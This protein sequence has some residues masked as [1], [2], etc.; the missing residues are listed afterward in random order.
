MS[1]VLSHGRFDESEF[2]DAVAAARERI[3]GA[4]DELGSK[5]KLLADLD[6]WIQCDFGRWMLLNGG[7]NGYWTR[8]A[9]LYPRSLAAGEPGTTNEVEHFFLTQLPSVV[10][11]Q[12]RYQIFQATFSRLIAP[13]AVVLSI[14]CGAMD[15]LLT[16]PDLP[17]DVQ[18]IGA[19]VDEASLELAR[20]TA[21]DL[22]R[23]GQLELVQADAWELSATI[24]QL[25][26]LVTS[27]GL[28]IYE[29]DDDRVVE[30][31][32]S[33][34]S[35]LKQGGR[36]VTSALT[37]RDGWNAAD[38][39]ASTLRRA[40]G[41]L[42]INGVG[43]SNLRTVEQTVAQLRTAGLRIEEVLPDPHGIFPTFVA[44]KD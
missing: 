4:P 3:A 13:G 34:A 9:V 31:Y 12:D 11:T 32:R 24:S 2:D 42:L 29:P 10:A 27:N 39:P 38:I 35:V 25:C 30:L 41:M 14:P 28:N 36:V 15:D 33:F 21:D 40:Q 5:D 44:V 16:L 22:G 1:R 7:W 37:P 18:L 43:W 8:Y 26:D 20:V 17:P 6:V 19:D 23:G